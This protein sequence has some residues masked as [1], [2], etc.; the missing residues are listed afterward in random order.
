MKKMMLIFN[1]K[2]YSVLMYKKLEPLS[3]DD[4]VANVKINNENDTITGMTLRL[5]ELEF[6]LRI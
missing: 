4:F 5:F 1:L 6:Q 2:Y 3:T